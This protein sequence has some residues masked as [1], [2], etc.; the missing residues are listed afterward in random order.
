[1]SDNSVK[2]TEHVYI[3]SS[4]RGGRGAFVKS[5]VGISVCLAI[6][7]SWELSPEDIKQVD[8]TSIEGFWFNHPEKKGW[9]LLPIGVAA[10]VNCSLQPNAILDWTRHELGFVGHLTTLRPIRADE[11]ILVDYE[12]GLPHGWIA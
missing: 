10:M 11:E 7:L 5:D 9:G 4:P 2:F 8:Q 12:I 6:S 3:A 1:M